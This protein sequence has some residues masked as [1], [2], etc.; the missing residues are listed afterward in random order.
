MREQARTRADEIAVEDRRVQWTFAAFNGRVNR[1]AHLLVTHGVGHGDRVAILSENRV[2]YLELEFACAKLGAIVAALNWRLAEEEL[3]YCIDLTTPKVAVVSPRY[4]D[5]L[6]AAP[7]RP[8]VV[9]E[10]GETYEAMLNAAE[11]AEPVADV[12]PEDGLVILYT[13]GTTGRPKG[14]VISHRAMVA[15]AT[16]FC[17][18]YGV[19]RHHVFPAW[20]PMFHMASTDQCIGALLLGGRAVLIDGFDL[21]HLWPVLRE[22][23]VGWMILMPGVIDR[24]LERHEVDPLKPKDILFI[25]A[26][27]DL[28]PRHQIAEV[29]RAL[30]APYLNS[31]GST[32]TGIPPASGSLIPIGVTPDGLSKTL[33]SFLRS[34]TGRRKRSRRA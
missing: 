20:A 11:D 19:N 27:A 29:T 12:D 30:N 1:L 8:D 25:G 10:L 18:D 3:D 28:I 34:P 22:H 14:A 17:A 31:F 23:R 16:V 24:L 7:S 21:D 33:N 32:E 13:S 26:M 15:R 5:A 6:V 4:R 2:E 9:I